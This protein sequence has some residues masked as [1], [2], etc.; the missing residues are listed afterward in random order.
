MSKTCFELSLSDGKV[1]KV[2][3][4][5]EEDWLHIDTVDFSRSKH[6]PYKGRCRLMDDEGAA[7]EIKKVKDEGGREISLNE[8]CKLVSKHAWEFLPPMKG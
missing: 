7:T 5:N 8:F 6:G 1:R 2:H 4:D 3:L